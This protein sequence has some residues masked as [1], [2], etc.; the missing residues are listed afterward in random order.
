ML[1]VLFA[2]IATLLVWLAPQSAWAADRDL[3]LLTLEGLQQQIDTP[4]QREGKPTVDLRGRLI[5]LRSENGDFRDRFYRLLQTHLQSGGT[6]LGLDLSNAV[7]RGPFDLQ[8]LSLREPLYGE[9][10]FPLLTEQAQTQLQRDRARLS[11]LSELSRSLLLQPQPQAVS[12]FLFRWALFWS[13]TDFEGPVNGSNLFFLG[14]VMAQ[15]TLFKQGVTFAESR[16]SQIASFMASQFQGEANWRGSLFFDRVRFD[17]SHFALSNFQ[18]SEFFAL[19]RFTQATFAQPANFNRVHFRGTADLAQTQWQGE[20]TFLKGQFDQEVFFTNPADGNLALL[21]Q[22]RFAQPVNLRGAAVLR[23]LDLG[24]SLFGAG[25]DLNVAN[26]DFN[27]DQAELLGSPGQVG[28]ILSVPSL[29]GNETLLRNLVRNFRKL[30]QVADA[31]QLEYL[32]ERLRLQHWQ[33]Q[34]TATNLNTAP[35]E[36]L[37]RLG[38]TAPQAAAIVAQ[39]QGQPLVQVGDILNIEGINLATYVKVRDR[40]VVQAPLAWGRRLQ[41][42]AQWMGLAVLLLM[43]HY[44][45]NVGLVLGVGMVAV[46]IASGLFWGVDRFRRRSPSPIAPPLSE[47]LWMGGSLVLATGLGSLTIGHLGDWPGRTVLAIALLAL[48]VPIGLIVG[49]YR[50]GRFHDQL[51]SSYLVEDGSARQLRLLIA[52]LPVIPSFPFFRDRYK[53]IRWDRRYTW[54]HYYDFSLNNWFKFGF[55]DLRLRDTAVPG[56]I[57]ALVWYQWAVGLIYITLL[58]WTLSRT[59]PGLNLLLYF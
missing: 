56:L 23:Q 58:L 6:P 33:R 37:Q 57:T 43:S 20:A 30:E 10:L 22:T 16:F 24:D 41:L 54:L 46:A 48:P 36:R 1:A 17:Q 44:G 4:V 31:N 32:T 15:G 42:G 2:A 29:T 26:L 25:A 40:V 47:Q 7:V 19:A 3:P 35:P 55:N 45:T 53:P 11:Q 51:D 39:R 34:L 59:I 12:L 28:R 8:R 13:Q 50:Q 49:I 38:F 9:A 18:N 5:D 14:P 27:A 52:R 21:R